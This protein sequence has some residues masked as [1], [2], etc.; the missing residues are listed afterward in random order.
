MMSHRFAL[1]K[2]GIVAGF[3]CHGGTLIATDGANTASLT[4]DKK[5]FALKPMPVCLTGGSNDGHSLYLYIVT[6]I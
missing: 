4:Y 5:R 1:E 6:V 2:S 3:G